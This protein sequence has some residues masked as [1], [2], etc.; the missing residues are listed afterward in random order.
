MVILP[1]VLFVRQRRPRTIYE[2]ENV[3]NNYPT[4]EKQ[5]KTQKIDNLGE[6]ND[7]IDKM[8]TKKKHLRRKSKNKNLKKS[9]V[10]YPKCLIL[11]LTLLK[12]KTIK[13][14]NT[15]GKMFRIKREGHQKRRSLHE[16]KVKP[17]ENFLNY[18]DDY[19]DYDNIYINKNVSVFDGL[20]LSD[21]SSLIEVWKEEWDTCF[22]ACAKRQSFVFDVPDTSHF[23]LG[24]ISERSLT[25][26]DNQSGKSTSSYTE[27]DTDFHS[28]FES[29][30]E[31]LI[32]LHGSRIQLEPIGEDDFHDCDSSKNGLDVFLEAGYNVK[33]LLDMGCDV[34]DLVGSKCKI[35]DLLDAGC[36]VVELIKAGFSVSDLFSSG[37]MVNDILD[38]IKDDKLLLNSGNSLQ[39]LPPHRNRVEEL[40]APKP[41]KQLELQRRLLSGEDLYPS[42]DVSVWLRTCQK[43]ILEPLSGTATGKITL[44]ILNF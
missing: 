27:S 42:C 18:Y 40:L 1:N 35:K 17:T 29:F 20:S 30:R 6:N 33:D 41:E 23:G 28:A 26:L 9:T 8:K 38:C 15:L 44:T 11:Q 5:K 4:S 24:T 14:F 39:D 19:T 34:E 37:F 32:S 36:N 12:N 3:H 22:T 16:S 13:F 7:N 21:G 25:S 2:N 43:E 31:S 10:N